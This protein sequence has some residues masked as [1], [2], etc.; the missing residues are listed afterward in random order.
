MS[1]LSPPFR[2]IERDLRPRFPLLADKALEAYGIAKSAMMQQEL[3]ASDLSRLEEISRDKSLMLRDWAVSVVAALSD[4]FPSAARSLERFVADGRGDV[5]V[6]A[7]AALHNVVNVSLKER[8]ARAGL[9]HKSKKVRVL[10][11]SKI[12]VFRLNVLLDE[13]A[14]TIT[15]EKDEECRASLE[16]SYHLLRDGHIIKNRESG[17]LY[18]TVAGAR[19]IISREYSKEMVEEKGVDRL[20]EALK[21]GANF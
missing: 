5:A 3:S 17:A 4:V 7:I 6:S 13:L 1:T 21:S 19:S 12:Q 14:Q 8:V 18:V 10:A 16:F 9:R 11:G 15:A 2:W 20:I